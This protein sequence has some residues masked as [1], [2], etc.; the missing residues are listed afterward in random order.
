MTYNKLFFAIFGAV[1]FTVQGALAD[2]INVSEW[3]TIAAAGL[4]AFGTW[5][6]PNTPALETA[7]TWV[8]AV[9]LGAGVLAPAVADGL[10]SADLVTFGITVLTA[11]GVYVLP[12]ERKDSAP[13]HY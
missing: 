11:A 4:A 12:K 8:N 1:L 13:L 5:L 7:K 10:S 6:M 3:V 9:V 2:G